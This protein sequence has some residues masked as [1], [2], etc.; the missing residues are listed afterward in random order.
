MA[1]DRAYA[2]PV[3]DELLDSPS[4]V[5]KKKN[6]EQIGAL[7]FYES[8]KAEDVL[9]QFVNGLEKGLRELLIRQDD[10]PKTPVETVVKRI[11]T[12]EEK[13]G[14]VRKVASVSEPSGKVNKTK[15]ENRS[16]KL[17]KW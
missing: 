3:V 1:Y 2:P 12:W 15:G 5:Q 16:V 9:C 4:A 13:S 6:N 17:K 7:A 10:L 14:G 8:R 11:V